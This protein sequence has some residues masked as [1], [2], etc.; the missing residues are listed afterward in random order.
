MQI[1]IL[2]RNLR[3]FNDWCQHRSLRK[4]NNQLYCDSCNDY[5][6]VNNQQALTGQ[7]FDAYIEVDYLKEDL[8]RRINK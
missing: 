1:A 5:H 6:C 3:D 7:Y 8:L 4:V 2:V